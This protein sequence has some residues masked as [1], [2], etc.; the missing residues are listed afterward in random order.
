MPQKT[1][2]IRFLTACSGDTDVAS[3]R[4]AL[5]CGDSL[6]VILFLLLGMLASGC[7]GREVTS[8]PL[9]TPGP[10]AIR[11]FV[12]SEDPPK[13]RA[14]QVP[15]ADP[16]AQLAFFRVDYGEPQD[17]PAGCFYDLAVGLQ[18]GEKIGWLT[19]SAPWG[20]GPDADS[21]FDVEVS[22]TTLF[23]PPLWDELEARV[24]WIFWS[25]LLPVLAVDADSPEPVLI[26]IAAGLYG[27]ISPH[28]AWM[29]LNN[30]E[31][32]SH[33]A[34]LELLACLPMFQGD[35]YGPSREAARS[36]P[37]EDFLVCDP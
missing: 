4:W 7:G 13:L 25:A 18:L 23:Q 33:P 22:D 19:V 31:I 30:P 37:G 5:G 9:P 32:Q 2:K 14:V 29:L 16:E 3:R 36:L 15:W 11:E 10:D 34:V 12:E 28:V 20:A 26:R 1:G 8:P 24:S 35:A 21:Y 17:C 27:Y 6:R